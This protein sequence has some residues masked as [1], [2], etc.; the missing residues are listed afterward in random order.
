MATA[1]RL[2]RRARMKLPLVSDERIAIEVANIDL[3]Q[4][5]AITTTETPKPEQPNG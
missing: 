3:E 2:S 5:G 4:R 1:D